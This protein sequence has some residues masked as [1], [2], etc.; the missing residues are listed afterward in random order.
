MVADLIDEAMARFLD[1]ETGPHFEMIVDADNFTQ[2]V[3]IAEESGLV[4]DFD[5]SIIEQMVAKIR[6]S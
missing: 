1:D 4:D 5:R 6:E 2:A 3:K